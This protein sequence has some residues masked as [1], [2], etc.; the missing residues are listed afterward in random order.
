MAVGLPPG[1]QSVPPGQDKIGPMG[2]VAWGLFVIGI[3]F[4]IA[5]C[6]C[7]FLP[8]CAAKAA[9]GPKDY[10]AVRRA[11]VSSSIAL[12]FYLVLVVIFVSL[13]QTSWRRRNMCV[14]RVTGRYFQC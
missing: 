3:F 12:C 1:V 13:S 4:P 6:I 8:M 2:Y 5:W 10:M 11:A 14:D 7:C 9:K